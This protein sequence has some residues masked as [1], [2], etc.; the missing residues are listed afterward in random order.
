MKTVIITGSA[1]GFG[2]EMIKLFRKSNFNTVI[3]DINE[4]ALK[5]AEETLLKEESLGKVL[6][7]K[8]DIT[9]EEDDE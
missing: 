7:V 1:R 5:T 8:A 2:Y 3:C 6:S 4:E 9:K